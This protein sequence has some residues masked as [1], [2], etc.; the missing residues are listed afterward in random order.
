MAGLALDV[1]K[2]AS[3]IIKWAVGRVNK[4]NSVKDV[5][6]EKV[7]PLDSKIDCGMMWTID[8]HQNKDLHIYFNEEAAE[9]LSELGKKTYKN[10]CNCHANDDAKEEKCKN[11]FKSTF[12]GTVLSSL[13]GDSI[14]DGKSLR[15]RLEAALRGLEKA[16]GIKPDLIR[17]GEDFWIMM[18][19]QQ[20]K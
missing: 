1:F 3:G 8:R 13:K 18:D 6:V 17:D 19:K 4:K 9:R 5:Y 12:L 15:T 2:E 11:E 10:I 20:H 16:Y 14:C 7:T